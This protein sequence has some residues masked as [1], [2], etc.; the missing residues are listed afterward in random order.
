MNGGQ[1]LSL[2]FFMTLSLI[3]SDENLLVVNKPAGIATIPEGWDKSAPNLRHL[4]EAEF[5]R[6]WIVH[7]LDKAT[8]GVIVFARTAEAHRTLSLFFESHAVHKTYHAIVCG[9]PKWDERT[10]RH[11]LHTNVGRSHRTVVDYRRGKPSETAF[12][13]L[14]R[15]EGYALLAA[16]PA[17]GRTHQVRAHL[18]TLGFPIIADTLYGAPPVERDTISPYM[19]RPALHAYS[20]AFELE[21]KPFLFTAPYPEDFAG[22][23]GKLRVP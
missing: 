19:Q 15:F 7:R 8:S 3:Y 16:V 13:V 9:A 5:G 11:P 1:P 14:E 18:A 12:R 2:Y 17:T 23:L 6:L 10:A 20:L 4:L 22:V 21:G